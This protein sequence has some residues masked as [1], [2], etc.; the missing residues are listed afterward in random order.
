SRAPV[1]HW[2]P[3]RMKRQLRRVS[4]RC[5]SVERQVPRRWRRTWSRTYQPRAFSDSRRIGSRPPQASPAP[6]DRT[7]QSDKSLELSHLLHIGQKIPLCFP[8]R[9]TPEFLEE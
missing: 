4:T 6:L 3:C 7:S 9:V 8:H 2:D 5:Q 1:L